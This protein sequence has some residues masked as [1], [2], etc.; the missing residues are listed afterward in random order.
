MVQW[1]LGSLEAEIPETLF[2]VLESPAPKSASP[3]E[4]IQQIFLGQ[5]S[6]VERVTE[7]DS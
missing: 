1:F 4:V 3:V 6:G 5:M 2:L 7:L